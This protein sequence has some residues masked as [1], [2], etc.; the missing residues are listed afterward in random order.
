MNKI[1]GL[2]IL[3]TGGSGFIG[4]MLIEKLSSLGVNIWAT[5]NTKDNFTVHVNR[6]R[7]DGT[8]KSLSENISEP[9]D[10][11]IHLA[12]YFLSRHETE[13]ISDLIDANVK[14][15]AHLLEWS[16]LKNIKF[17][18]NTSTY[19]ISYEHNGYNPQNLYAATKQ[20]YEDIQQFYEEVSD[21][22]FITLELTDT[23]GPN[24]TRSKFINLLLGS[25]EKKENFNMSQG[26]QEICYLHVED[27]TDAYIKCIEMLVEG[28]IVENSKFSIYSD[29]VFKLKDMV[30]EVLNELKSNISIKLGHYSYRKREI[31]TFVPTYPKLP[32]WENKYSL[33][34]GVGTLINK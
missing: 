16:H 14:L 25:I 22:T 21:T 5:V 19:A 1:K 30:V 34:Q 32:K 20:A 11:I 3:V 23:Y 13:Q 9:I 26:E 6:V 18:I 7:Y 10:G 28:T 4:K 31:M 27:A 17:F 33:R 15:G 24:D 2:N 29:E 8:Y 12:T